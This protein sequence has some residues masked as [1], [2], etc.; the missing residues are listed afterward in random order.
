MSAFVCVFFGNLFLEGPLWLPVPKDD[1]LTSETRPCPSRQ[2]QART[3]LQEVQQSEDPAHQRVA[4]D[5][6]PLA[7]HRC[8]KLLRALEVG[9]GRHV[10][11]KNPG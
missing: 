3:C 9:G 1:A 7:T 2:V 5:F 11:R 10:G 4:M 8:S 6:L